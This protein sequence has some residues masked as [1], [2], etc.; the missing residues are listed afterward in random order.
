MDIEE[1]VMKDFEENVSEM[2]YEYSDVG[3]VKEEIKY[4][5]N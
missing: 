4:D 5:G 3:V 2:L 1:A